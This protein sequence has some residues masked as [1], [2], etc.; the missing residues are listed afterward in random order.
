MK[1]MRTS[2][3]V[4]LALALITLAAIAYFS[5]QNWQQFHQASA[6]ASRAGRVLELSGKILD[7]LRDAETGQRGFVLTGRDSYLE[8]YNAA[9]QNISNDMTQLAAL[10]RQGNQARRLAALQ[11]LITEKLQELKET[12]ELRRSSGME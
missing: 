10:S 11:P 12:I 3:L 1:D 7:L 4:A 2:G 9:L 6:N 5:Y 8:P